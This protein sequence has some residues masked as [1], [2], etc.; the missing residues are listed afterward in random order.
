MTHGWREFQTPSVLRLNA[1][2][3]EPRIM[4]DGAAVDTAQ[5]V[6]AQAPAPEPA[7]VPEAAPATAPVEV[8]FVDSNVQD[9]QTL[10]AGMRE[11]VEV[12]VL[13]ANQ[14]GLSQ[15]AEAL[16]GRSNID[17]IH[18]VSHGAEGEVE[19][20]NMALSLSNLDPR[21]AE[22]QQIASSLSANG[23][24]LLYGCDVANG[25]I[26][27]VFV[28]RLGLITGADIA[29]STDT[30]GTPGNWT[31]EKSTGSIESGIVVT[32]STQM[33]YGH[34]LAFPVGEIGSFAGSSEGRSVATD[35]FGNVYVT[36]GFYGTVDFAPELG[37]ASLTDAGN[38]DIFIQK[39][40]TGGSLVWIRSIGGTSNGIGTGISVDG[41]GNVYITGRFQ[42]TGD[43][44]PGA[45]VTSLTSAGSYDIFVLKMDS[46]GNFVW[47]KS[48]GGTGE[49]RSQGIAVD[50]SG[51]VY[52]TGYFYG[53][54]DFDPGAGTS[55]LIS[56]AGGYNDIFVQKLD[57]SGNLIWAKC[58]G[59]TGED[60]SQGIAVDGSGNV[61][62]TGYFSGTVDFDPG[63]GVTNLNAGNGREFVQKLD[64]DGNLVWAK[65]MGGA[66]GAGNDI[67][68][69]GAG[70]VY[71]TGGFEGTADFDPGAGVTTL[72]S[73]GS[74]D[75]FVQKLDSSGNLVW[76]KSMGG[77]GGDSGAGIAVDGFGN[78]YTTGSFSGT[79]D[80]DPG[81]GVTNLS[82]H[83]P[84][85]FYISKLDAS[86]GFSWANGFGAT[87][88]NDVNYQYGY[89]I[90]VD[91]MGC[92][93]TTGTFRNV[94]DF[95]PGAGIAQYDGGGSG[96][97]VLKLDSSGSYLWADAAVNQ[98]LSFGR[99][100][101]VDSESN[102]YSIGSFRGT[103]DF[104][105]GPEAY[106]LTSNGIY[107]V[108]IQKLDRYGKLIWV[109]RF[110]GV[111]SD[112][113]YGIAVDSAGCVYATGSFYDTVDFDP[114]S[115][116]ANL[117]S[118]PGSGAS[119]FVLKLDSSGSMV[120]AKAFNTGAYST[121]LDIKVDNA[122][123]V[124]TTGNF[125]GTVDF[126]PGAGTFN[127]IS[128]GGYDAFVLKLGS[129]GNLIWAD[130]FGG[131]LSHDYG[132]S[133][134]VDDSGNVH[135]TGAFYGTVDFDPGAGTSNLVSSGQDAYVIKLDPLG[136][137]IW[138]K[139]VGE[140]GYGI[141]VDSSG[142]VYFTGE[143]YGTEDF[144]TGAG[145]NNLTSA[146]WGDVFI[147][148]LDSSGNFVWAKSMGGTGYDFGDDVSDR[149]TDIAVDR[150]GNIFTTGFFQGT[151]DFD[152]GVGVS[153]LSSAGAGDVFVQKLDS[154]GNLVWAKSMGGTSSDY[155]QGIALDGTGNV[156][157]SGWIRKTA[158]FD[159]G[160]GTA[161]LTT[162]GWSAF[163]N[164]LDSSGNLWVAPTATSNT[165]S[166]N[167]GVV[168]AATQPFNFSPAFARMG[169]DGPS[170][171]FGGRMG[172]AGPFSASISGMSFGSFASFGSPL[173][174]SSSLAAPPATIT[175]SFAMGNEAP[176]GLVG[177]LAK[178]IT[179]PS[180]NSSGGP[181]AFAPGSGSPAGGG[182]GGGGSAFSA[183]SPMSGGG[184]GGS[185]FTGGLLGGTGGMGGVP[186]LFSSLGN[187]IQGGENQGPLAERGTQP[188]PTAGG[189]TG[190]GPQASLSAPE[191]QS[192]PI[193][194]QTQLRNMAFAHE[195]D[196]AALL[197]AVAS[198]DAPT[199][200]ASIL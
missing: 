39:F 131:S 109:E 100:V 75:I 64:T 74:S 17:A 156:I 180:S 122:G 196:T 142:N 69:D 111:D 51:N 71:T 14:D 164:K 147:E 105:P 18:I 46:S 123:N 115:A 162:S 34:D 68:V 155:G 81:A 197:A 169:G 173:S 127:L 179:A 83:H 178:S 152:P 54:A 55:N 30:T 85:D 176:S 195:A 22:L 134:A 133:I 198:L 87:A 7:P 24:I 37:T 190:L 38:G 47:S 112:N 44:D 143:F 45:G 50:G 1:M 43:F 59:N 138:V 193:A 2:A 8:A 11:G 145:T 4:F 16:N 116:V 95:D 163:V 185:N 57:S 9:W 6:A 187:G 26:G 129:S 120:W 33:A 3:L 61:Y 172:D 66:S 48:M 175:G 92:I 177:A 158:D 12:H 27:N 189:A 25:A 13:D 153:N 108:F 174:V 166:N 167:A 192:G 76:A 137:L 15:I 73:N 170:G 106:N 90:A 159:P 41:S 140:D 146:G 97:F 154:G 60:R 32:A 49:D 188:A 70:N 21:G 53:T 80:F 119:T 96:V 103:Y 65:N 148:K 199:V 149:G 130:S 139:G 67:A 151:A 126:D 10:V 121:G 72:T 19:L 194:F 31:L 160:A 165:T 62:T 98:Q 94:V 128:N 141:A 20:G 135:A 182:T 84:W 183:P 82:S 191:M 28:E 110:G 63:A 89:G 161:N 88:W 181:S 5:D 171:N 40:N 23:D 144:D 56:S 29:A 104:D 150:L 184:F 58:M 124:Y 78:V 125:L 42:G 136:A 117:S 99:K 52:T 157:I 77:T 35:A 114:G 36:G 101:A 102:I 200:Q 86:G 118:A 79:A 107:D 186:S 93:L 91:N 168:L 113:G 132:R